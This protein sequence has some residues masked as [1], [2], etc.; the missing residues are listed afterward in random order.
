[1]QHVIIELIRNLGYLALVGVAYGFMIRQVRTQPWLGLATGL[2]FGLGSILAM[3]DPV[4]LAPGVIFDE[5]AVLI[6]LA[7]PFG[8]PTAAA[9]AFALGAAFRLWLGG[10][11]AM[12]GVLSMAIAAAAGLVIWYMRRRRTGK[13]STG[14]ILRLAVLQ[15]TSLV[16]ILTLPY[17]MREIVI[18]EA[19]LPSALIHFLGVML[20][21]HVLK[22]ELGRHSTIEQLSSDVSTDPLTGLN[23]RR[24]FNKESQR[25]FE[26]AV[27]KRETFALLIVD[28]DFFKSVNDRWGHDMGD[29]VIK[30]VGSVIKA[31]VRQSDF[32]ARLGGEE[33][34]V[35]LPDTTRKEAMIIAERIRHAVDM[36]VFCMSREEGNVTISIGV[37]AWSK[38]YE[39]FRDMFAD[40]DAALY[41]AKGD[42][43]NQVQ[44]KARP[45]VRAA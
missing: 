35:I 12:P 14:E 8:G 5:R 45:L 37:S 32:V 43:R 3:S 36:D 16:S 26:G 15:L 19:L 1:M 27:L 34:A 21:G 10:V 9:V 38:A 22:S 28:I 44:F 33:L 31:N 42:G 4:H 29:V 39:S 25:V 13:P 23:N 17:E 20:L 7:A 2:A 24:A 30:Q 41:K 40:A 11:G 18:R 6:A